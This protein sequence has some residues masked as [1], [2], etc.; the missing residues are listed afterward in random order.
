ML[1]KLN[2][3][4]L[5]AVGGLNSGASSVHNSATKP[6]K[7]P[8]RKIP[9]DADVHVAQN[10]ESTTANAISNLKLSE[11]NQEPKPTT[12]KANKRNMANHSD[13][14]GLRFFLVRM[15]DFLVVK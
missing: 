15:L 10:S 14:S 2:K 12:S 13:D 7:T 8:G 5:T 9:I 11:A 3:K 6:K 4:H 1:E